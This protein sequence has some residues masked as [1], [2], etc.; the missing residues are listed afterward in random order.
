MPRGVK[1]QDVQGDHRVVSKHFVPIRVRLVT[2][3]EIPLADHRQI[4]S[5]SL[6][7]FNA[8]LKYG[9]EYFNHGVAPI[10]YSWDS[11]SSRVLSLEVPADNLMTASGFI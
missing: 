8:V 1:V 5:E 9:H 10:S 7:K 3:I 2:D 4:Y 6:V 11:S